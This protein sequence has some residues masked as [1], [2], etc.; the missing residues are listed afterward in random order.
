[1]PNIEKEHF[2]GKPIKINNQDGF[3]TETPGE[4]QGQ[5]KSARK[6]LEIKLKS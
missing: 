6:E 1:M 5:N 3:I 4:T 2:I